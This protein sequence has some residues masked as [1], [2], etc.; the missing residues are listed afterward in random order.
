M[1]KIKLIID[2]QI[3]EKYPETG[4]G[5]VLATNLKTVASKELPE[6][7][8]KK[9]FENLETNGITTQNISDFF[10]IKNWREVYLGCGVKP[11]TYKPSVEALMRRFIKNKY[12]SIHNIVDMYNYISAGFGAPMGGYDFSKIEDLLQL[13][14]AI[15][16]EEFKPIGGDKVE[17]KKEHIVYADGNKDEP[18]ICWMWNNRDAKRTMLN[19]DTN[20]GLFIIDS[21]VELERNIVNSSSELLCETLRKVGANVE[22]SG[23]L[24]KENPSVELS[25]NIK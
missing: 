14:Y 20:V 23:V 17:I 24:T 8:S 15:D 9:P 7:L 25:A 2:K 13:R 16:S 19:P 10:T 11:K 4:I 18:V 3:L 22:V 1:K 12:S 6:S 5:Y 21:T